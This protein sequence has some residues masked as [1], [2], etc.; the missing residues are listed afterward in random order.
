MSVR[1]DGVFTDAEP[2]SDLLI[3]KS[4]LPDSLPH[5]LLYQGQPFYRCGEPSLYLLH[6]NKEIL[7]QVYPAF[8]PPPITTAP[9]ARW[10]AY[11]RR[12]KP[13]GEQSYKAMMRTGL[14]L[15]KCGISPRP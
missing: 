1:F 12:E 7:P 15:G 6:S 14:L 9:V 11:A 2:C 8:L 5:R 13:P 3:G 4:L 10:S